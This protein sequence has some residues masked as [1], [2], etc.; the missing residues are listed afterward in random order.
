MNKKRKI[1]SACTITQLH[2]FQQSLNVS[3]KF[4]WNI[5]TFILPIGRNCFLVVW[6][7]KLK[8]KFDWLLSVSDN[9][10]NQ[11]WLTG[12]DSQNQYCKDLI[13]QAP[14]FLATAVFLS[15]QLSHLTLSW[16]LSHC[17]VPKA[18]G[19]KVLRVEYWRNQVKTYLFFIH[20][21]AYV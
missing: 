21:K 10:L 5:A 6:G 19:G 12:E 15:L 1:I 2:S 20:P 17:W 11:K 3:F 16:R 8:L 7:I 4:P 18:P 14:W 13:F 9:N